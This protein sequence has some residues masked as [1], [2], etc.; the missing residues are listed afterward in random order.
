MTVDASALQRFRTH[1]FQ[2]HGGP[3]DGDPVTRLGV[4]RQHSSIA[5]CGP[6][7][8]LGCDG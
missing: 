6:S 1:L 7:H 4:H 8:H 2:G 5:V 3:Q